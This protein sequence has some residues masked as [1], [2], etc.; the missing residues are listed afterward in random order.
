MRTA[1]RAAVLACHWRHEIVGWPL[2][3]D[4]VH[5]ILEAEL[6]LPRRT[7]TVEDDVLLTVW[8]R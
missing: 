2:R 6:G 4:D 7:T 3:A 8:S 5:A 1:A